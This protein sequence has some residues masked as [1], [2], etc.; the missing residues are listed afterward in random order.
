M[1]ADKI[2]IHAGCMQDYHGPVR[3]VVKCCRCNIDLQDGETVMGK[4]GSIRGAFHQACLEESPSKK[5]KV[6]E[7]E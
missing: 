1:K 2:W 3:I 4:V 6:Y 5:R 7:L